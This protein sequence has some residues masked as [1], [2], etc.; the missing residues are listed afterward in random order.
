MNQQTIDGHRLPL[1][2]G[3]T[4]YAEVQRLNAANPP[5]A[6]WLNSGEMLD[7]VTEY[8][9]G[10]VRPDGYHADIPTERGPCLLPLERCRKERP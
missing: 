5:S 8:V 10:S 2:P 7:V 3:T 6:Y 1:E 4:V 9:P